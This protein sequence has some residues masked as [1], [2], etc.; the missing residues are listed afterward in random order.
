MFKLI[1]RYFSKPKR[2]FTSDLH[3]GHKNVIPYCNRPYKDVEEMH[4]AIIKMWNKTVRKKDTVYVLGDFSL[5]PKWSK[6]IIPLLNGNKILISGNHDAT[7]LFP[8][9]ENTKSAIEGA[10]RRH[11]KMCERYIQDGWKSIHQILSLSLKSGHNVLLSHLPFAPKDK[12]EFDTKYLDLRPK[13]EGQL[14]LCGHLHGIFIKYNNM[15]DV[16]IDAH[17]MKLISEDDVIK[18]IND[19]RNYIPSKLTEYYKTKEN[20]YDG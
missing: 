19:E 15:I 13:D 4:K 2:F 3:F 9:K 20:K 5:N 8:A 1:T 12:E 6:E 16:G 17:E 18:L 14:L 7:F 11:K 10:E